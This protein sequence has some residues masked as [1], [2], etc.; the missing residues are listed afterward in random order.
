MN[1]GEGTYEPFKWT[2]VIHPTLSE[3]VNWVFL[4]IHHPENDPMAELGER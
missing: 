1:A 4:G 2:Q 3:V